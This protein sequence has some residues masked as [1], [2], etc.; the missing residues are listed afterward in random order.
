MILRKAIQENFPIISESELIEEIMKVAFIHEMNADEILIDINEN[1]KNLPMLIEGSVKILREDD[2]G[3]EVFLYYVDAG[4]TCAATLTC[5][6]DSKISNIRAVVEEDAV[7]LTIPYE[8]MDIWMGKYRS[9][10]EFILTTYSLRFEE[11]L[12]AVDQLAFKKMDQRIL[13]FLKEKAKL[14]D[15]TFI[16]ISHQQIAYDLNTSRE[17]VSR[18]LKQMEKEGIVK[19]SRGQIELLV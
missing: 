10:R 3:N 6:M 4:N 7:F 8:Y 12:K 16:K 17:V 2:E 5:C 9:W 14:L 11:L 13:N 19:I 18:I 1:I 15:N